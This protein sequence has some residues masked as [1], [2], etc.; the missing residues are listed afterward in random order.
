MT[1]EVVSKIEVDRKK[2]FESAEAKAEKV[3]SQ[4]KSRTGQAK[5]LLLKDFMRA[6]DDQA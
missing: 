3:R 1:G 2:I 4:A 5:E 6:I